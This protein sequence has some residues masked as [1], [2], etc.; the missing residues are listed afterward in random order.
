MKKGNS[1]I[2][3]AVR[4]RPLSIKEK[5]KQSQKSVKILDEKIIIIQD[6][7]AAKP[8]EAFRLARSKEKTYAFD[9]A[10][11]EQCGQQ[12]IFERTTKFLIDGIMQGYNASVFA[13]GA[14]GAGKTYT[15]LGTEDQPGIMMLSIE[16]L[17][18][19]IEIYS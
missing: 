14:T 17:F 8:E 9:Y 12:Y 1:N 11:D 7:S 3:V 6:I 4:C 18:K 13:Y 10:F 16:E 5:Q 2:L 15:M 19:S